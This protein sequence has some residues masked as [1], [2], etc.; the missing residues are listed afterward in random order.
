M[1]RLLALKEDED[2][3]TD[4]LDAQNRDTQGSMNFLDFSISDSQ[5]SMDEDETPVATRPSGRPRMT[6]AQVAEHKRKTVAQR[7]VIYINGVYLTKRIFLIQRRGA[8]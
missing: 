1:E 5:G 3:G 7:Q 6:V 4:S 2:K 8:A